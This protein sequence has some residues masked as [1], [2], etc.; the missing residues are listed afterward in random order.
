MS[1]PETP[2][3]AADVYFILDNS[4]VTTW[5]NFNLTIVWEKEHMQK[6]WDN[7]QY[8]TINH[9][10]PGNAIPMPLQQG[11]CTAQKAKY[12]EIWLSQSRAS[13]K[14]MCSECVLQ[15]WNF[16]LSVSKPICLSHSTVTGQLRS[17]ARTENYL[18]E[19]WVL[20]HIVWIILAED[21][22]QQMPEDICHL[23]GRLV[24]SGW[25]EWC[26][27]SLHEPKTCKVPKYGEKTEM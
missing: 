12:C 9:C 10:S 6:K 22:I 8:V 15:V 23:D 14:T 5:P 4:L 25:H 1:E 21:N 20:F 27:L 24:G 18:R 3:W 19:T 26:L 13:A 16:L 2:S 7:L 17:A 11:R